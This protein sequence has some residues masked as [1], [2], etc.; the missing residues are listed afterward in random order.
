MIKMEIDAALAVRNGQSVAADSLSFRPI[1][2][3]NYDD[4]TKM[5]TVVGIIAAAK[6]SKLVANCGFKRLDFMPARGRLVRIDVP[7]LTVREIR[8]LEQQLPKLGGRKLDCSPIPAAEARAFGNL[9]R[10][11]PNFA[12]L[13]S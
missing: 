7:K 2:D 3:I 1:C 5:A 9:Y 4:G 6:D 11:L 10:Y 8:K 13:E 12:V